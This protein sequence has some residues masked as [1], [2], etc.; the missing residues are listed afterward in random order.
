MP[1]VATVADYVRSLELDAWMVGGAVRDELLGKPV[2]DTDFVVPGVGYAE[3]KS[4]LAPHGKVE[5]LIVADQHVG[6][7]LYPRDRSVRALT[8][9]G[10]EFAPPRVERSTGPGRHDFEI[11]ADASIPLERDMERRDFTI[12]AIAKQLSTGEMLDPLGGRDDLSRRVLRT[13]SPTSFRDDPLRIVRGLRFVAE[14]DLEPD[15]DTLRQMREWS[16]QVRFVSAE[17]IGGGLTADGRGELSKLLL[18]PHPGKALRLARDVGVLTVVMPEFEAALGFELDTLR[19]PASVDE[20]TF[21]VVQG[22]ADADAPLAV[23]LAALL[24]DLGKPLEDG[25]ARPHAAIG[26]ELA[27][28]VLR[29]LRYPTALHDEVV[30]LVRAHS[31]HLDGEIGGER[32]RRFLAEHGERVARGLVLLKRADLSA[33]RIE[34]WE[35]PALD[36]LAAALDEQR[37]SPYRVRDL[38]IGGDD[39]LA[40][41][42]VEGPELGDALRALL[43]EVLADPA[44]NTREWLSERAERM[45]A[46]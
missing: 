46:A 6:V 36:R 23:R 12:N 4:A 45:L 39:L 22:T 3:L 37:A 24:H 15:E 42:Y 43:D 38:A 16:P 35:L 5:D 32:A 17:R 29:R 7:R 20:H 34:E 1:A 44:R 21:A 10:I 2:R 26:A 9:A 13:T 40:L 28:G 30:R 31:F 27:D 11:V 14:L 19:Q 25:D 41:G 18:A 33:K 8:P